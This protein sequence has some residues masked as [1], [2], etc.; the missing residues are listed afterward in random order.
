MEMTCKY[1]VEAIVKHHDIVERVEAD[2]PKTLEKW[3]KANEQL[4]KVH[5][6]QVPGPALTFTFTCR[7]TKLSEPIVAINFAKRF[8]L[9]D[10]LP[11]AFLELLRTPYESDRDKTYS[12]DKRAE[13]GKSRTKCDR[14]HLLSKEDHMLLGKLRELIRQ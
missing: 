10:I 7:K 13:A 4:V 11:A 8:G 9:Y 12:Q 5:K 2:W 1:E 14:W 6:G 3:D